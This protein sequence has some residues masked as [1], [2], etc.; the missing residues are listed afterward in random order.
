MM[1]LNVKIFRRSILCQN[2]DVVKI[3]AF[4]LTSHNI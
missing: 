4:H 3:S 1:H 2:V